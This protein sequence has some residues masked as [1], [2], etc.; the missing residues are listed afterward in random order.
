MDYLSCLEM[1]STAVILDDLPDAAVLTVTPTDPPDNPDGW[2]NEIEYYLG[3]AMI[4]PGSKQICE[5][6]RPSNTTT[7]H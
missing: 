4:S 3:I 5:N 2:L 6:N 7:L 1:D